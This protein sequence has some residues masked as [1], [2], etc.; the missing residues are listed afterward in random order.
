MSA[1]GELQRLGTANGGPLRERD[2]KAAA[3]AFIEELQTEI[4][5]A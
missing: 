5:T 4:D 2:N 1:L 3:D